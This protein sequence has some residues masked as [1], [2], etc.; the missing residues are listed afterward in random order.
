MSYDLQTKVE[1]GWIGQLEKNAFVI[2]NSI[3][4]QRYRANTANAVSNSISVFAGLQTASGQ[5]GNISRA[6][7]QDTWVLRTQLICYTH[8]PDDLDMAKIRLLIDA[9]F[10]VAIEDSYTDFT[11]EGSITFLGISFDTEHDEEYDNEQQIV[12]INILTTVTDVNQ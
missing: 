4:I 6:R 1:N 11:Q 10:K 5:E 9:C 8:T 12:R 7:N 3:P 2:A